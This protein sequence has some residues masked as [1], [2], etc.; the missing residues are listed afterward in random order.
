LVFAVLAAAWTSE[1]RAQPE[2]RPEK[3]GQD[4]ADAEPIE[5]EGEP[6]EAGEGEAEAPPPKPRTVTP[7]PEDDE[8]PPEPLIPPAPNSIGGHFMASA[9]ALWAIPFAS[10]DSETDQS[11]FISAGPGF[12]LELALGVSRS[13][14]VG[15]WGQMLMLDGSDDC[16]D[17]SARSF[18]GGLFVRYH[19]VQGQ[20]FDPWMSAGLGYRSTTIDLGTDDVQYGGVEWLR[21]QVGGDWYAFPNVGFGPY[22]ELDMGRYSSRSPGDFESS[23]NHWHFIVGARVSLDVPGK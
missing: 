21:V 19:L 6:G 5:G 20:R 10:L 1:V 22:M 18:A 3:R 2:P 9:S 11:D 13:V 4:A 23:A 8:G 14:A 12:Q 17:C 7:E 16:S 15:G